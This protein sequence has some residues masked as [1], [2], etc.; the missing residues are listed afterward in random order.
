LTGLE[1]RILLSG[2]PDHKRLLLEMPDLLSGTRKLVIEFKTGFVT[3]IRKSV[4]RRCEGC[5]SD[6]RGMKPRSRLSCTICY[7]IRHDQKTLE[8]ADKR[9]CIEISFRLKRALMGI[10]K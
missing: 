3:R 8:N 5:S 6:Q 2:Y 10:R 4:T 1:N 7:R 9:V